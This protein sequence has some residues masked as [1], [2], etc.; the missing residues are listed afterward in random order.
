MLKICLHPE[1]LAILR[2]LSLQWRKAG[3]WFA[4]SLLVI[5]LDQFSKIFIVNFFS[6]RQSLRLLP[7]FN[8]ILSYNQ[9]ASFGFLNQAG[10]WQV[11]FL[12]LIS[13]VVIVGLIIWLLRLSYPNAWLACALSMILGGAAGNLIDRIRLH[14]VIDFFDFH[15]GNWHYATFN[16]A[17]SAIVIGVIM[18]VLQ[19]LRLTPPV[20]KRGVCVNVD[21]N[22]SEDD[23]AAFSNVTRGSF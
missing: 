21:E 17:D 14:Y 9:G 19:S 15:L 2:N 1:K 16:V 13:V 12:S 23:E 6:A 7:F 22:S 8:L 10:G 18:I 5:I 3:P 20:T 11:I 4:V